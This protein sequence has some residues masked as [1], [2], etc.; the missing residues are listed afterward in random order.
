MKEEITY[1]KIQK[2]PRILRI[3]VL[4]EV[5]FLIGFGLLAIILHAKL[6]SP[7][8]LPGHHGLEFMALMI[9]GRNISRF[10]YASSISSIGAQGGSL[11]EVA[12]YGMTDDCALLVN[13][14]RGIIYAGNDVLF[15][16]KVEEAAEIIQKD[17]ERLLIEKGIV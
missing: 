17:M 11:E 6:R 10:S 5:L 4:I 1:G 14:S 12:K 13:S 3:S 15:K 9:I 7:L 8:R 2:V 16:E